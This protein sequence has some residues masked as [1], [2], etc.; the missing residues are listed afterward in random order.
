MDFLLVQFY[1]TISQINIYYFAYSK[2]ERHNLRY[3]YLKL[4]SQLPGKD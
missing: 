4:L 2:S 1:F 3:T